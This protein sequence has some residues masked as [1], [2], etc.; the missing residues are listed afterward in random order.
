M[1]VQGHKAPWRAPAPDGGEGPGSRRQWLAP[2]SD[3]TG[4]S[5][6]PGIPAIHE[7]SDTTAG[8]G[9][10]PEMIGGR[11]VRVSR[12]SVCACVRQSRAALCAASEYSDCQVNENPNR[13]A[14]SPEREELGE[15]LPV[16]ADSA[17]DSWMAGRTRFMLM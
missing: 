7:R 9:T 4:L 14:G 13:S 16:Q 8:F 12:S 10:V 6:A 1:Q 5:V 11:R 2:P 3:Q 17:L 15:P